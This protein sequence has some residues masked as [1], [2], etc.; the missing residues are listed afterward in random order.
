MKNGKFKQNLGVR[1]SEERRAREAA[2]R[3]RKRPSNPPP[4]DQ[5]IQAL[6]QRIANG[7]GPLEAMRKALGQRRRRTRSAPS[8]ADGGHRL[9]HVLANLMRPVQSERT[10]AQALLRNLTSLLEL[11]LAQFS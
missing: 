2:R 6:R 8:G 10:H 7:K 9:R 4:P 3:Q 1:V 5:D 11:A